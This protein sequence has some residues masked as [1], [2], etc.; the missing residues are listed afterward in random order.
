MGKRIGIDLG[1]TN[2]V[3]SCADGQRPTVLQTRENGY[4]MRSIVSYRTRRGR[5]DGAGEMLVGDTAIDNM[6]A[7]VE[8]TVV[9]I[10]RLMGRRFDD[11]EVQEV[12]SRVQYRIVEPSR[13][14]SASV[15]VVIAGQ[16]Y[17]P[18]DISAM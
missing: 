11:K 9:S 5:K 4:M 17:S 8:D 10:K 15:R 6:P 18:V 13:G 2:S 1:T 16:E 14:T 3:M 12:R 7:A